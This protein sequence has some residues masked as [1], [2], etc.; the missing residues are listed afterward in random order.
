MAQTRTKKLKDGTIQFYT[1][2]KKATQDEIKTFVKQTGWQTI[3]PDTVTPEIRRYIG[4]VKGGKNRA[5]TSLVNSKGQYLP[6][7]IQQAALKQMGIDLEKLKEQNNLPAIRDIFRND[8]NLQNR[9]DKIVNGTGTQLWYDDTKIIDKIDSFNGKILF[10]D[11]NGF[12]EKDKWEVVAEVNKYIKKMRRKYKLYYPGIS[13]PL[14]Y[15]GL[16]QLKI[17]L[18]FEPL[19]LTPDE[20]KELQEEGSYESNNLQMYFRSE[21]SIQKRSRKPISKNGKKGKK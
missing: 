11:G 9:F 16:K 17:S 18:D 1:G 7:Y 6:G 12:V 2:N 4:A 15:T 19:E 10:N 13:I 8:K 3:N 21:E 20:R 14:R 5:A